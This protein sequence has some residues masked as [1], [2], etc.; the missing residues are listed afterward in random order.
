MVTMKKLWVTW[1]VKSSQI[2][3][4]VSIYAWRTSLYCKAMFVMFA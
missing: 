3:Q 4:G 1:V 2:S